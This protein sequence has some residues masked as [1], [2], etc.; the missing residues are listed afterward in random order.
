MKI[1]V[2][3]PI[4]NGEKHLNKSI[5]S[6][7]DQSHKNIELILIN[8]GSLD[9]SL[10]ICRKYKDNDRRVVVIDIPNSGPG[11]ARNKGLD[12]ARGSYIAF[13]DA[14]DWLKKD[15][16]QRLLALALKGD[17]Q[18]VSANFYRVNQ[19]IKISKNNYKSGEIDT[20][21]KKDKNY[22]HFKTSSSF[23][24][25]WGKLYQ[26]SFIKE[27]GIRFSQEKKVFLEDTLFNLKAISYKPKYYVLNQ[28][29]YYYNA[30]EDSISR[31]KE[32]ITKRAIKLLARYE[33]FLDQEGSYED[34]LDLF[35]PLGARVIAWSL[36]KTVDKELSLKKTYKRVC[37]FS[38][39][40]TIKRLFQNKGSF[41][42]LKKIGSL[43]QFCLYAFI[44][45]CI[46][47]DLKRSL[48]SFFYL[49]I[50]LFR[51]YIK[52]SVQN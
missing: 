49:N 16:L 25:V 7:L 44:I 12:R 31:Q 1:S 29:L 17:Y 38:S 24:Y 51:L 22:H 52:Y 30:G 37:E 10:S 42:E 21:E 9:N 50:P 47:Y 6:V 35:I 4:Y 40:K 13:V 39:N 14:D 28:P 2:I 5:K 15:A 43:A 26:R 48:T 46:R 41:Q 33:G 19:Q 23:G 27:N 20:Y 3:M 8:D 36:M 11:A 18:I 34:N 32:D 45:V